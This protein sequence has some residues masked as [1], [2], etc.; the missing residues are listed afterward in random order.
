MTNS[1]IRA[2]E[3]FAILQGAFLRRRGSRTL[4]RRN[5]ESLLNK[6]NKQNV[7][8]IDSFNKLNFSQSQKI[9][10]TPIDV[11]NAKHQNTTS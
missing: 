10:D 2:K 3:S 1:W 8:N 6:P 9:L 11:R 4:R 7:Y 5:L